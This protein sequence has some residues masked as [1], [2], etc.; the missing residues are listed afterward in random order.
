MKKR[1][2]SPRAAVWVTACAWLFA[3]CGDDAGQDEVTITSEGGAPD[4]AVDA[5][6][7]AGMDGGDT[8]TGGR[9]PPPP[10][11]TGMDAG[12]DA[13][14]EA[15]PESDA[16]D[17]NTGGCVPA[18]P[19]DWSCPDS[20]WGD[21]ICDCGCTARDDDC[22]Q[23][24]CTEP[25][26]IEPTCEACSE[27]DGSWKPCLPPPSPSD[28][29]CNPAEFVDDSCDCG[30]GIPDTACQARG[31]ATPFCRKAVCDRRHDGTTGPT[32]PV[33]PTEL[34][35]G[36][37][38][39]PWDRYG[40]ED[41]CDCGC[42]ALDPDCDPAGCDTAGC[43]LPQCGRCHDAAGR[44]VPCDVAEA[45]WTCSPERYGSGDG[46]DCGCSPSIG[47]VDPDCAGDGCAEQGCIDSACDRCTDFNTGEPT[48]CAPSTWSDG[49]HNCDP[50]NYGTGDGCDCGCGVSD[51]DCGGA[52]CTATACTATGCDVCNDGN[53]FFVECA[54]FACSDFATFIGTAEC[55][56]G[57]GVPD[58]ACRTY[59]RASCT[60]AGCERQTCQYCNDG[61]TREA[62]PGAWE[63]DNANAGSA[64][65]T[66]YYGLD[67]LCDCGCGAPDLDCAAGEGC[68]E[69]GCVADGC[70]V[71]HNGS[72]NGVCYAW[73]CAASARGTGD[74]CDC[75]CGAP[76]PD[77]GGWPIPGGCL[78]PG[79]SVPP[80]D[81]TQCDTCHDPY[82]REVACP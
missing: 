48:G 39:C 7:D 55:D 67:G 59:D 28:W 50:D 30:C 51:P 16:C 23:F 49:A 36:Q 18:V 52:G 56:C 17:I 53:G 8:S 13:D 6:I 9:R 44:P 71:C 19:E 35:N 74:G 42:G 31:C 57:C 47:T 72:L 38:K 33:N 43:W 58:P 76:D 80:T 26:C 32:L 60:K 12:L 69:R 78:E 10:S 41:G 20:F 15:G 5:A 64:C 40:A 21:G 61:S 70:E 29:R 82:G 14:L 45:G 54:D 66:E 62:C 1:I 34:T 77:C 79:C 65:A 24:S 73:T 4:G 11:D 63:N 2:P 68:T 22:Q 37:W 27:L 81:A 46:C 75:G 3:A 25:G